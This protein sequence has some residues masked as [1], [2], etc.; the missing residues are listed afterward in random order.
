[1]YRNNA[2]AV[3]WRRRVWQIALYAARL[4]MRTRQEPLAERCRDGLRRDDQLHAHR[5]H[6]DVAYYNNP[7]VSQRLIAGNTIAGAA[8][9]TVVEV[10]N[11][12]AATRVGP[13]A[14]GKPVGPAQAGLSWGEM[15]RNGMLQRSASD[16]TLMPFFRRGE[17]AI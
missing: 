8:D 16:L 7:V 9:A 2:R 15:R 5:R 10:F 12:P 4:P 11:A 3:A 6:T 14:E 17:Y 13:R 1:M